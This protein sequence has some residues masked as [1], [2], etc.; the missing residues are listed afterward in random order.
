MGAPRTFVQ[1]IALTSNE[2]ITMKIR[3]KLVDIFIEIKKYE[4]ELFVCHAGKGKT[5]RVRLTKK[6]HFMLK[7]SLLF[8]KKF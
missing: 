2:K 8:C 6:F 5:L 3:G 7:S 1:T 4:C